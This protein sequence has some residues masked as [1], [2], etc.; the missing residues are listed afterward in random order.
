MLSY[1]NIK[2]R[3]YSKKELLLFITLAYLFSLFS[4]YMLSYQ[5]LELPPLWTPDAGLYGFYAESILK[6]VNY[7][8][9]SEYMA[10]YLLAYI[11]K[12]TGFSLDS[13]ILYLPIYLSSLIV[14]PIILLMRLYNLTLV[15]FFASLISSISISYYLRTHIGYMDTDSL[16]L[17][18]LTMAIYLF[19]AFSYSRNF[20][21][22]VG[23]ILTLTLFYYWYHSSLPIIGALL[24]FSTIYFVIFI[25]TDYRLKIAISLLSLTAISI[26]G[27]LYGFERVYERAIDYLFKSEFIQSN[28]L[29][30]HSTLKTVAEAQGVG[31]FHLINSIV[32]NFYYFIV[33]LIGLGFL[34]IK[35]R[36]LTLLLFLVILGV[37]AFKAGVRFSMY[38]TP[39]IS[40][41]L[42]YFIFVLKNF[43]VDFANFKAKV[44]EVAKYSLIALVISI[45]FFSIY[46]YNQKMEPFFDLRQVENLNSLRESAKERDFILSWWDYGWPLWYHSRLKTLIDNGKH[47]EDNYII[48]KILFSNNQTFV[49]NA[50]KYFIE[51]YAKARTYSIVRYESKDSKRFF[52]L[53]QN[54]E[55]KDFKLPPK[56]RDIYLY[57]EDRMLQK[58]EAIL[59]FSNLKLKS[60][61]LAKNHALFVSKIDKT[62]TK[63]VFAKDTT[64]TT[65]DGICNIKAGEMQVPIKNLY[66]L[67]KDD[68]KIKHLKY[69]REFGYDAI[70]YRYKYL[71]VMDRELFNSFLIQALIFKRFD[72]DYFKLVKSDKKSLILKLK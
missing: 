54:L 22:L 44:S 64:L 2:E 10:G 36:S 63:E 68:S 66:I 28:G 51:R 39:A 48:S 25:K 55:S 27:Y 43:M 53:L 24:L 5:A 35:Y 6:G 72:S 13:L 19:I 34:F 40:I 57:L 14:I 12:F 8:L 67:E 62:T 61:E 9:T 1:L 18:L 59:L 58:M 56:T 26:F 45:S 23:Y 3:E 16:N 7:P 11:S 33:G 70:V 38:L 37:S 50:S 32:G 15:G 30:F 20:L 69:S 71:M 21:Y 41:G 31:F 49:A 4:R 42:I 65:T 52:N 17:T 46:R 29:Y 60:K 47:F